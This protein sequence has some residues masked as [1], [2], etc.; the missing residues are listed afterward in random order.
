MKREDGGPGRSLLNDYNMH[1]LVLETVTAS[2]DKVTV[3]VPRWPKF[4]K[5]DETCWWD[6]NLAR[7]PNGY[8]PCNVLCAE[9]IPPLPQEVRHRLID[10]YCPPASVATIKAN[11]ADRDCLVRPYLGR[12]EIQN[13]T[14][15]GRN[16]FF[17]LRNYPLHL[18]QAVDLELPIFKYAHAMAEMLTMIHWAAKIDANDVEFVLGGIQTTTD[19]AAYEHNVYTHDFLGTHSLWILDFDCCRPMSMDDAGVDQAARAFLR[20][21]P[22]FPHP[23]DPRS[24]D[25]IL[26]MVFRARYLE[27]SQTVITGLDIGFPNLPW[28]FIARVTELH[29]Q[30]HQRRQRPSQEW[31]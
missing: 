31:C 24:L 21:D 15:G 2:P 30:A 7:F 28:K 13:E 3:C 4:V 9:R 12:R 14:R 6:M 27:Y 23:A 1:K 22:Y 17:S 26:W 18:D 11:D 20:N 25:V 10:R 16:N 8:T 5:D 19:I 29:E